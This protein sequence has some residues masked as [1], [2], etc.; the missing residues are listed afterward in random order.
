MAR[1]TD[2]CHSCVNPWPSV[3]NGPNFALCLNV[4][5]QGYDY[6]PALCHY[7]FILAVVGGRRSNFKIDNSVWVPLGPLKIEYAKQLS[8]VHW[9]NRTGRENIKEE[10][11]KLKNEELTTE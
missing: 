6:K 7:P 9:S 4:A 10:I 2:R 5:G 11:V 3:H 1:T 8:G